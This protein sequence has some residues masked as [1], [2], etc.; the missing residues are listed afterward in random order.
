MVASLSWGRDP[1]GIHSGSFGQVVARVDN[2]GL[3]GVQALKNFDLG[4]VIAAQQHRPVVDPMLL[5]Q[6]PHGWPA[7]QR[8]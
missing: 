8:G 3:P 1:L 6:N 7:P 2:H 4:A 5:V